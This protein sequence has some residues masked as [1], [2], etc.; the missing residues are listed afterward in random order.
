[1]LT[2][3]RSPFSTNFGFAVLG[4]AVAGYVIFAGAT[5]NS[6]V[7][8]FPWPLLN[9]VLS[10]GIGVFAGF[11]GGYRM[12]RVGSVV[13]RSGVPAVKAKV[14]TVSPL[15]SFSVEQERLRMAVSAADIGIWDLSLAEIS[16]PRLATIHLSACAADFLNLGKSTKSVDFETLEQ[17]IRKEDRDEVRK[18]LREAM[19]R[20]DASHTYRDIKFEF[21]T[22]GSA[23]WL[24]VRGRSYFDEFGQPVRLM[25]VLLDVTARR[26][27]QFALLKTSREAELANLAKSRFLSNVSHELRTPLGAILGFAELMLDPQQSET[28]RIECLHTILRNGESLRHVIDDILDVV[29]IESERLRI[30]KSELSLRRLMDDVVAIL[31]PRAKDKGLNFRLDFGADDPKTAAPEFIFSDPVRLR[32]ILM[33]VIGNAVKFTARGEVEIR[34]RSVSPQYVDFEIRDTGIGMSDDQRTRIF[35]MF[36][37]GDASFGRE[38]G[39]SGLGLFLSRKLAQELGGYLRL[40]NTDSGKGSTFVLRI[41]SGLE[42]SVVKT[43]ID[44]LSPRS[45]KIRASVPLEGMRVLI[46][47]DAP[48]NCVLISRYLRKAGAETDSA[49]N[50]LSGVNSAKAHEYDVV[51]MDLQMPVLDGYKA[52]ETLREAHYEKPIVAITAHALKGERERCLNVGA[53]EFLEKPVDRSELIRVVEHYRQ[54]QQESAKPSST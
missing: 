54:Q 28:D 43:K 53:D 41:E 36:S 34:V 1:M 49:E 20:T 27:A 47:D 21:E 16:H 26:E 30:E 8:S 15:E 4:V 31:G 11:W 42:S 17:C 51:L 50:G 25:G 2:D 22:S 6:S 29:T 14:E 5:S 9:L 23:R 52:I 13:E 24:S 12:G 46:V 10:I 48:D 44:E 45:L 33:N 3:R 39:G 35:Q 37:Q 38:F 19:T 40:A 32:Q 18:R 7:H